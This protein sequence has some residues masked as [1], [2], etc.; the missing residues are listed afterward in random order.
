[1]SKARHPFDNLMQQVRQ[2][3]REALAEIV[4]DHGEHVLRVVRRMLPKELRPLFDSKDFVQEVWVRVLNAKFEDLSFNTPQ[5]LVAFFTKVAQHV[6]INEAR[7][8][9]QTQKYDVRRTCSLDSATV[10]LDEDLVARQPS[11]EELAMAREEWDR[12]LEDLPPR[13]QEV[14]ELLKQGYNHKEIAERL[15]LH[16]RTVRRLIVEV[17]QRGNASHPAAP[18][19]S[20]PRSPSVA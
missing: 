10:C 15:G 5:D 7:R 12:L 11:P 18:R 9:L 19:T 4:T 20:R 17:A 1:M 6:L 2:G 13:H 14:F 3:S 16:P 8:R